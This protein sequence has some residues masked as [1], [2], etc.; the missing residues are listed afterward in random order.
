M[1]S[2]DVLAFLQSDWVALWAAT[3]HNSMYGNVPGLFSP[4]KIGLDAP[5]YLKTSRELHNLQCTVCACTRH[6]VPSSAEN[7]HFSFSTVKD[8]SAEKRLSFQ[9][10]T[11]LRENVKGGTPLRDL[12]PLATPRLNMR[13][14]DTHVGAA[15]G[16]GASIEEVDEEDS[17]DDSTLLGLQRSNNLLSYAAVRKTRFTWASLKNKFRLGSRSQPQTPPPVAPR[18]ECHPAPRRRSNKARNRLLIASALTLVFMI[19]EI[20]GAYGGWVGGW[21]ITPCTC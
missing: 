20:I 5:G 17:S 15:S 1:A 21:G 16:I 2:G 10:S 19:A 18:C 4:Y 8:M 14:N 13:E 6:S 12:S 9:D 3:L 7:E 11:E